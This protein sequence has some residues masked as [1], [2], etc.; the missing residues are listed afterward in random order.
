M[1]D[2]SADLDR[3]QRQV[4]AADAHVSEKILDES[5][6]ALG[7]C[8]NAPNI[9]GA[10]RSQHLAIF[11]EQHI[12]ETDLCSQRRFEIMRHR[13]AEIIE[14]LRRFL[15]GTGALGHARFEL[16]QKLPSRCNLNY[17]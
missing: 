1:F 6:L 17:R 12:R 13:I 9:F 11:L 14:L 2:G 7:G 15:Q 8:L 5:G 16:S 3:L 10:L 4:D